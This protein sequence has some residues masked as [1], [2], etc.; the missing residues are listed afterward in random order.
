MFQCADCGSQNP[1]HVCPKHPTFSVKEPGI[2]M[3]PRSI[4]GLEQ[5]NA[6]LL[7]QV[8]A[9][10]NVVEVAKEVRDGIIKSGRVEAGSVR[11]MDLQTALSALDSQERPTEKRDVPVPVCAA[12]RGAFPGHEPRCPFGGPED[13][14]EPE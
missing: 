14:P 11:F 12:C 7:L 2:V 1:Y 5:E 13:P 10:R 3:T 4:E 8:G 9:M 6:K